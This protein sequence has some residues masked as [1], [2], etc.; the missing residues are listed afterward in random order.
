MRVETHF[1]PW[2]CIMS[3][4]VG[5]SATASMLLILADFIRTLT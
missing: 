5:A 4:L 3:A 1:S 2:L